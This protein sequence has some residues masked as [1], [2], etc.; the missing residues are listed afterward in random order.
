LKTE[1][2]S[3][4]ASLFGFFKYDFYITEDYIDRVLEILN[5]IQNEAYYVKMAVAW[6]IQVA[7]VKFPEK[8]IKLLKRNKIDDWTYNKALQKIKQ[9][10]LKW[11]NLRGN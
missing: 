5:N 6:T 3:V 1:K 10:N 4:S 8:T 2:G 9:S 11:R 7:F